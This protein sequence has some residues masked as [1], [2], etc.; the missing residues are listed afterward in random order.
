MPKEIIEKLFSVGF[1][2]K[3]DEDLMKL[4]QSGNHLAF[5]EIYSRYKSPLYSYFLRM[6][7]A[8]TAEE[9]LQECFFNFIKK[10]ESFRFESSFKTWIWTMANH[11]LI[12]FWR[13]KNHH[14]NL[15]TTSLEEEHLDDLQVASVEEKVLSMIDKIQ[16]ESCIKKLP[17]DQREVVLLHTYSELSHQEI[18]KITALSVGAIK[19]ILFRSKVKLIGCCQQGGLD[20]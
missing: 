1:V 12:D 16:L 19:S 2:Y 6:T 17:E 7:T 10:K 5:E 4:F 3:S 13:S 15:K 18:S 8:Q 20:E 11:H 9:L 14:M